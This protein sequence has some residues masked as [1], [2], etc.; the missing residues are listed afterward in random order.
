M[1]IN[2]LSPLESLHNEIASLKGEMQ[3]LNEAIHNTGIR[4]IDVQQ[5]LRIE[6]IEANRFEFDKF[7]NKYLNLK[8]IIK[9]REDDLSNAKYYLLQDL[10][11]GK[12][13][14]STYLKTI[15]RLKENLAEA[16]NR[17]YAFYTTEIK[18]LFP[19]DWNLFNPAKLKD[20]VTQYLKIS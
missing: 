12:V 19:N 4:L 7:Y 13:S 11:D 5:Q 14:R 10:R 15:M 3:K 9:F 2:C 1:D 20:I 18:K 8:T 17:Y 6:L 16:Q